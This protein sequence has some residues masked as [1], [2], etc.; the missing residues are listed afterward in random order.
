MSLQTWRAALAALAIAS[1]GA[2]ASAAAGLHEPW[3]RLLAA[4]V[5]EGA[6][7]VARFDYARLKASP[8]GAA[9]LG[10]YIDALEATPV[11]GLSRDDQFAFWANAYNALTVS[12]ILE[13]W[14]VGSIREIRPHPFAI[15]PW[16]MDVTVI[17]GEA[18]SLDD[19]EHEILRKDWS[20]PRVHYAVNCASIGCPDLQVE[21]FEGESLDARLDAAARAYVNHPRGVRV[22]GDGRVEVSRIYKW[23]RED[24]G[25]SDAG[26]LEHLRR[27][28]DADLKA[29]LDG[30]RIVGHAYDW[31]I[32]APDGAGQ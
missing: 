14:P 7:G 8:E 23:F 21:P 24:F 32:N 15:G 11:S 27:Y 31:S 17:G 10:A 19:I 29:A 6:D 9:A 16:G 5:S 4:Y 18:L 26:V 3:G 13:H 22:I 20:D 2:P 1:A 30:A 25:G 28:A 12:V